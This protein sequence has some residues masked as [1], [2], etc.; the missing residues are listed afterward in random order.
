VGG[1]VLQPDATGTLPQTKEREHA[2]RL[3]RG[4]ILHKESRSPGGDRAFAKRGHEVKLKKE[5]V[6]LNS[7]KKKKMGARERKRPYK[8][9][10][11][12]IQQRKSLKKKLKKKRN[13]RWG[14]RRLQRKKG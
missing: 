13:R 5:R 14:G 11:G 9:S 8:L 2:L 3:K 10:G 4:K 1:D 7:K 6:I 12:D